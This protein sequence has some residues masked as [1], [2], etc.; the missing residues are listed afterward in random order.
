M[1][2]FV[3]DGEDIL[4]SHQ[5]RHDSLEHLALG[6]QR[7]QLAA[8]TAL[9][10]AASALGQLHALPQ[11]ESVVVGDDDLGLVQIR[12]HVAGHDLAAGVIAVRIIGQQHAQTILDGQARGDQQEASGEFLALR[13]AHGIDGLPSD[14]HGHD[15][16]LAS[17]GRQLERQAH[18]V[19]IGIVAGL[20]QVIEE[21]LAILAKLRSD[22]G[23][24]DG[25]LGRFDLAE[26]RA[27]TGELVVA[28]MF[29]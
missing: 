11:F 21:A 15:R 10:Q 25:G 23:Q 8:G 28:P 26:K 12:Q 16:G 22:L 2:R 24:P 20:F 18:Q 7:V 13:M 17:T 14:E 29:Q 4:Q 1:V 27:H 9:Q 19:G 5:F 6:F 3:V